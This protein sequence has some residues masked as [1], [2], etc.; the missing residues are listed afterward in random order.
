MKKWILTSGLVLM[1]GLSSFAQQR[2]GERPTPEQRA[3]RMTDKMAE[4]LK[5]SDDQKKQILAINLE[6]A[7]KREQDMELREKEN[8]ARKADMEAKK[9]EMKKQEDSIKAIL[10]EEQRTKWEEIKLSSK[11]RGRRPGGQIEDREQYR[12]R[13]GGG[14]N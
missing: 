8:E 4:E 12:K 2:G 13:K 1:I 7:K 3:T 5:L 11:D 14:S 9:A 6:N 10:T